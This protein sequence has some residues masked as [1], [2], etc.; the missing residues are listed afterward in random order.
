MPYELE[1]LAGLFPMVALVKI[2]VS[3]T[4]V[5]LLSLAAEWV[6]PRF[7]GI[8]SGYP[9]G[10][11]ISLFFIGYEIGP[12]FAAASAVYTTIGLAATQSFVLCYRKVAEKFG[13]EAK[14]PA[15]LWS[16]VGGLAGYLGMALLIHWIPVNL[17]VALGVSTGSVIVFDRTFRRIENTAIQ[18]RIQFSFKILLARAVTAAALILSIT[19]SAG[20]VGTNW[21]GLLSA[22]PVTL[23]PLLVI[24]H[25][26]YRAEHVYTII[27]NVP[28]GLGSLII[29]TLTVSYTYRTQGIYW[30]T[31]TGYVLAT[32]YLIIIHPRGNPAPGRPGTRAG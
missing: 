16:S 17:P 32:L 7:A 21:A 15:V 31:L 3:I 29:Y 2:L 24:V 20:I 13:P 25:W 26:S 18:E 28:R 1:F 6:N 23:F 9:L 27:K 10:A 8:L 14:G 5:V 30:G 12:D 19:A 11:A 22:F 4:M